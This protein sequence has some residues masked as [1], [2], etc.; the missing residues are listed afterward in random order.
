[1]LDALLAW[2]PISAGELAR[3]AGVA[4]S[5]GSGHLAALEKAGLVHSVLKGRHRYYSI[6][7]TEVATALES[8][9]RICPPTPVRSLGQSLAAQELRFA[10]TCYDHLAGTLGVAA[11]DAW[12]SLRAGTLGVAAL[13]AW[14]SLR[15]L[16]VS[17][18]TYDL[19]VEGQR[20]L[21][22]LGVDIER[23]RNTRR[24]FAR[25]CLDWTERRYHLA[26]ALGAEI[27]RAML[28]RSWF[29]RAR[30]GRGL[31]L[32]SAGRDGLSSLGVQ[33]AGLSAHQARDH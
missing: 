19:T 15:W 27:T 22:D 17:G 32:T 9:S 28:S 23:A 2:Y 33:Q 12:L 1:M 6:A 20:Q 26:G 29:R 30:V 25:P 10:R 4:A 21:G 8:L 5:T 31:L 14:L 13:D 16:R 18:L 7:G 3:F 24:A 11:L